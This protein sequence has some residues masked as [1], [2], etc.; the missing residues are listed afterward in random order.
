MCDDAILRILRRQIT[1]GADSLL[2]I[3]VD[4][5]LRGAGEED[6]QS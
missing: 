6:M 5:H 1:E 3:V 4:H 2:C